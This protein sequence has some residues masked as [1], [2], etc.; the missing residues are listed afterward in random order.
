MLIC[1]MCPLMLKTGTEQT[2]GH[3]KQKSVY[4]LIKVLSMY[5]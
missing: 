1:K 2:S 4:R 5:S 3:L